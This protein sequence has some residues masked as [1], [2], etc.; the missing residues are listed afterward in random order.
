MPTSRKRSRPK[1]SCPRRS[2]GALEHRK[3]TLLATDH[4]EARGDAAA[5]LQLIVRDV[6]KRGLDD[7]FWRPW[8]VTRLLQLELFGPLLPRWVTSRWILD[9]A[10]QW[11]D[12]HGADRAR[13]A[14]DI[15]DRAG[16]MRDFLYGVEGLDARAELMDHD[17]VH[18]QVLLYELGALDA[19]LTR[20]ATA[21][22]LAGAD[23]IREWARAPMGA[24][25]L[26]E[27]RGAA[28]TW[29]DL[30]SGAEHDCL[31]IGAATSLDLGSHVIGRLVPTDQGLM[32]ESAP[33]DVPPDV[34]ARVAA[35]PADWVAAVADGCHTD[36]QEVKA[37]CTYRDDF[38]LL[39]DVPLF[40]QQI[41]AL[42]VAEGGHSEDG[43]EIEPDPVV[44]GLGVVRAALDDQLPAYPI[45]RRPGPIVAAT[46]LQP[47]VYLGVDRVLQPG[48]EAKLRRLAHQLPEPAAAACRVLAFASGTA[49]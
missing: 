32:F 19:F 33:L 38:R 28:S 15:A 18:R 46:L 22:L 9:Q 10:A 43:V 2:A 1:K 44:L 36:R 35:D 16:G 27:D 17:W 6:T 49:H 47:S 40:T 14:L 39:T 13:E 11:L 30:A 45:W 37:I 8:R 21:D 26:L 5:A 3:A 4:A 23:R 25:R 48:D 20:G 24:F 31:E 12:P 42:C 7:N 29:V 41:C 34:A